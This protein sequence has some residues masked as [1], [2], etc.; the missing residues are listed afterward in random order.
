M[1]VA[2]QVVLEQIIQEER[3]QQHLLL[4]QVVMQL[5]KVAVVAVVAVMH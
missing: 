4:S 2:V 5:G 3:Q 1:E